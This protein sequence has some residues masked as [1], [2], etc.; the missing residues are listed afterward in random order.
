M[1]KPEVLT[2]LTDLRKKL[3]E[4]EKQLKDETLTS[5]ENQR[6]AR[7]CENI[8]GAIYNIQEYAKQ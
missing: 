8:K 5:F 4:L 3:S 7:R 1:E 6:I 2:W